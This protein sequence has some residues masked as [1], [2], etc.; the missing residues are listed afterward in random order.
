MARMRGG[1]NCLGGSPFNQRIQRHSVAAT[2]YGAV[3][4][5]LAHVAPGAGVMTRTARLGTAAQRR[6]RVSPGLRE[7]FMSVPAL[8]R[9]L[10]PAFN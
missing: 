4:A 1:P 10:S 7:R 3:R 5:H 2:G 8:W 9:T 6:A